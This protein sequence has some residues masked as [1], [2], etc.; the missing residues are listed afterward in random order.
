MAATIVVN[1]PRQTL[2][3]FY[4]HFD[5]IQ[6]V[7]RCR[8][9]SVAAL[10]CAVIGTV[11]VTL[12]LCRFNCS[13]HAL[14]DS[15]FLLIVLLVLLALSL[16]IHTFDH[17]PMSLQGEALSVYPLSLCASLTAALSPLSPCHSG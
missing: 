9:K 12:I 8:L 2:S 11:S 6:Y 5:F 10:Q 13:K 17:S 7:L 14:F 16:S 1:K 4:L 15:L 3:L